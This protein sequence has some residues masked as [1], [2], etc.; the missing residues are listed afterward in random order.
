MSGVY[1][2]YHDT[3]GAMLTQ[4]AEGQ[5]EHSFGLIPQFIYDDWKKRSDFQ[6]EESHREI[7][8]DGVEREFLTAK[9]KDSGHQWTIVTTRCKHPDFRMNREGWCFI[10]VIIK[11]D[12]E[13]SRS[14]MSIEGY[15][16]YINSRVVF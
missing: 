2:V 14:Q 1:E 6:G 11:D 12:K 4:L 13:L 3:I 10:V 16:E 15:T 9:F 5:R 7:G 8:E